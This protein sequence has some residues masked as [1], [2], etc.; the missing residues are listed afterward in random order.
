[1]ILTQPA[2]DEILKP[3]K[4]QKNLPNC[5]LSWKLGK[6]WSSSKVVLTLHVYHTNHMSCLLEQG[7]HCSGIG[8]QQREQD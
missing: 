4:E 7:S 6:Q 1:M 2:E 8:Q 3:A 5:I